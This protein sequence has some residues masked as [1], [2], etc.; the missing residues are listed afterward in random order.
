VTVCADAFGGVGVS[1]GGCRE[2]G[3]SF[4][5]G[6]AREECGGCV[7]ELWSQGSLGDPLGFLVIFCG[8]FCLCV[9]GGT[10]HLGFWAPRR[11]FWSR[12][13]LA[14]LENRP[15]APTRYGVR[16]TNEKLK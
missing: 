14:V 5:A 16:K 2:V 15:F 1:G 11:G 9:S 10:F 3:D 12:S 6:W 7:G 8:V 4:G 13:H